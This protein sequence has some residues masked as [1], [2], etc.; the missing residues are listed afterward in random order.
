MIKVKLVFKQYKIHIE[1]VTADGTICENSVPFSVPDLW[2]I[3]K[4]VWSKES[5][6]SFSV[7]LGATSIEKKTIFFQFLAEIS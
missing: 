2:T 1:T 3:I 7:N 6:N 4:K 5:K